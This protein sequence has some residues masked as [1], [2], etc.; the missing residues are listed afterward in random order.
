MPWSILFYV[1]EESFERHLTS[2]VRL[3]EPKHNIKLH[4]LNCNP[5]K[6]SMRFYLNA[7]TWP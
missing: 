4:F 2:L 5:N 3:R 1:Q 7:H 6:D